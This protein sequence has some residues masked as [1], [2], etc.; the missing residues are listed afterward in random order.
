MAER[1]AGLEPRRLLNITSLPAC[2]SRQEKSNLFVFNS[3]LVSQLR[4]KLTRMG[5]EYQGFILEQPEIII[6]F[7]VS[8]TPT[9]RLT[10]KLGK[11]LGDPKKKA[12]IKQL[13]NADWEFNMSCSENYTKGSRFQKNVSSTRDFSSWNPHNLQA[14]PPSPPFFPRQVPFSP[15]QFGPKAA[16]GP[17]RQK[18]IPGSSIHRNRN[19]LAR[20]GHGDHSATI[21]LG[22]FSPVGWNGSGRD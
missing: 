11:N 19:H 6:S 13:G 10:P 5:G 3:L 9:T 21:F 16:S 20:T 17:S 14:K 2:S 4:E 8:K 18:H 7:S 22:I 12:A 15:I 1:S